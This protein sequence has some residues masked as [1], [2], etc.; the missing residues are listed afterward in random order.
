MARA[1]AACHLT[2]RCRRSASSS[3]R[4]SLRAR[5][6]TS[7]LRISQ[8]NRRWSHHADIIT[9]PAGQRRDAVT[10]FF[11][12]V[13]CPHALGQQGHDEAADRE[14]Q[15]WRP[16]RRSDLPATRRTGLPSRIHA[17]RL[18]SE[19]TERHVVAG[20]AIVPCRPRVDAGAPRLLHRPAEP[21]GDHR[22]PAFWRAPI[23]RP[24]SGRWA[25]TNFTI[26]LCHSAF[27][28]D[29]SRRTFSR[30]HAY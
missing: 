18:R 6:V 27:A 3:L 22:G 28:D 19:T 7:A 24:G 30:A 25:S 29:F 9:R 21:D 26:N 16:C 4:R 2:R 1:F 12:A 13:E 8:R 14:R 23:G 11:S 10:H 5:S 15:Q 20:I 17:A